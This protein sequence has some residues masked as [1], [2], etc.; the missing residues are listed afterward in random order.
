M[1][2][3][4]NV[5]LIRHKSGLGEAV[6]TINA[7]ACFYIYI[8][9]IFMHDSLLLR[10]LIHHRIKKTVGTLENHGLVIPE[11]AQELLTKLTAFR[12]QPLGTP[13]KSNP[14]QQE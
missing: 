9:E 13:V 6:K 3:W 7:I 5:L 8:Q 10:P 12:K 1:P 4:Q 2:L 11:V 14:L